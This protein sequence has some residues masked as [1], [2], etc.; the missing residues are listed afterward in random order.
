MLPIPNEI[1]SAYEA[2]LKNA[3]YLFPAML[4]T[5]NGS[6]IFSISATDIN[7]RIPARSKCVYLFKS[8]ETRNRPRINRSKPQIS[9]T[10]LFRWFIITYD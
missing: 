6:G 7:C 8:W 3:I 9:V 5:E 1:A 4:I 10:I 2:V